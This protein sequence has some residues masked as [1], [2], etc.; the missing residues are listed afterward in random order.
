[1]RKYVALV[2]LVG[3]VSLVHENIN[4]GDLT[5]HLEDPRR[6]LTTLIHRHIAHNDLF[7]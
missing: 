3:G 5:N 2:W 1:L 4:S 6:I 7:L